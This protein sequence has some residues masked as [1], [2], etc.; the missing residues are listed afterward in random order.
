MI[1]K[2]IYLFIFLFTISL[3][4]FATSD[5][6][7]IADGSFQSWDLRG[8][9][10]H[11]GEDGLN[12]YSAECD[13]VSILSGR[14]GE[15]GGNGEDG[16]HGADAYIRYDKVVCLIWPL[17]LKSVKS[18]IRLAFLSLTYSYEIQRQ[19]HSQADG[20]KSSNP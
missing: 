16:E 8:S 5:E 12:A 6:V 18:T 2:S 11:D 1:H 19:F 4:I 9:D 14:D 13:D 15:N 3:N 17:S 10:G 20:S 7:I